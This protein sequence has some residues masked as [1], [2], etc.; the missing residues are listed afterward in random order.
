MDYEIIVTLGPSSETES[1]WPALLAAGA[2]GFRLNTSHLTLAQLRAWLD[3][4]R[5]FLAERNPLPPLILDLQGSK[6]RL[7]DFPACELAAGQR[8]TLVG[9]AAI[10]RPQL[11]PVPHPDFFQAAALSSGEIVLDD[12]RVRLVIESLASDSLTARVIQGGALVARKGI[13]YT[14]S[15]YRQESLS[16]KDQ[17]IVADTR[18]LSFIRYAL[19]YVKDA[20]EMARYRA[21]CGEAAYLIA[22]LERQPAVEQARPIAG[23]ADE[24]WLCRGDLGAELG[25]RAMAETVARFAAEVKLLPAPVFLAGQVLEHLTEHPAPTRSEVCHLYDL[26]KQG[27]RGVVLSD[28]TAIGRDPVASCRAAALFRA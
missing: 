16:E 7:G 8:V 28:E 22:K 21:Y 6:W 5:P 10:E 1:I 19:S 11:L 20:V 24:L 12:A 27:Y 9:A 4:L 26:L 17:T 23:A 15:K 13:T 2:T 14:S 18:H 25:A 3:R